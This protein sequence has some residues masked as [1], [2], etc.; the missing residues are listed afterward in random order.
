VA[1]QLSFLSKLRADPPRTEHGGEIRRGLRKL[2]RPVATRRP[3]HLV[4]RSLRAKGAWS[5]RRPGAARM[6]NETLRRYARRYEIRIYEFANAGN[7]LHLLVR[8][9]CRIGLHNFLR[10]FAGIVARRM[11]GAGK[12]RRTGPFWDMLAYSRVMSWGRDFFGVRAYVVQNELEALRVVPYRARE[13]RR[14][15][16]LE[17]RRFLE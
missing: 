8:S 7:H 1:R 12:G 3:M 15:R 13:K 4:M 17:L 2:A 14:A 9:K 5:M 11:T 10:V 6:V 16:H